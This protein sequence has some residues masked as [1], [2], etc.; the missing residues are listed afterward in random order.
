SLGGSGPRCRWK[1]AMRSSRCNSFRTP[2]SW[3]SAAF[4]STRSHSIDSPCEMDSAMDSATDGGFE[5]LDS[6]TRHLLGEL[7]ECAAHGHVRGGDTRFVERGPDFVV[8]HAH[9]NPQDD[10]FA[11]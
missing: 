5:S 9:F 6:V 7:D 1:L 2:V 4:C 3:S 10:G 11:V 8:G